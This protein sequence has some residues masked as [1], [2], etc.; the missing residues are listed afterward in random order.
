MMG[1]PSRPDADRLEGLTTTITVDQSR[2][3]SNP[4]ST[5]GT[6][7][8]VD[9]ML[10]V[11][12]SR[13]AEPH[14]GGPKAFAFN[15]ASVSG[16]GAVTIETGDRK[17]MKQRKEFHVTG[18]MCPRC[19]GRGAVSD[20]DLTRLYDDSKSLNDGALTIPGYKAGSWNV[21]LYSESGLM[22][23]DKPIRDY[24]KRELDNLLYK[25]P[26][27][28]KAHGNQHHLRGAGAA[29]PQVDAVQGSRG[30]AA[31]HPRVR[32]ERGG[33]RHLPRV[34]GHPAVSGR[35]PRHHRPP[36]DRR[37]VRDAGQRPRR[38]AARSGRPL[39]GPAAGLRCARPWTPS[40]RSGWDTCPSIAPRAAC[41]EARPSGS[42]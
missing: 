12:F 5:V 40:P 23:A 2:L 36:V 32:R 11:L 28:I 27:K 15:V 14:I 4:R 35:P 7:T 18:G 13:L 9:A 24:S 1:S 41:R 10:R 30:H 16:A 3:G 37:P 33:L 39:A 8:D 19:E 34:R 22:D 6:V 31:P 17:G 42:R 20:I 26:T 29:D 38:V 25:E 21:R